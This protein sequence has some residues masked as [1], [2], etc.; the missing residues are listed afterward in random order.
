MN[1]HEAVSA[2]NTRSA[3]GGIGR[4]AG[5]RAGLGNTRGGG[6]PARTPALLKITSVASRSPAGRPNLRLPRSRCG[7]VSRPCHKRRFV[8]CV[9][10]K[11]EMLAVQSAWTRSTLACAAPQAI[12][13]VPASAAQI[14]RRLIGVFVSQWPGPVMPRFPLVHPPPAAHRSPPAN[15]PLPTP[16]SQPGGRA[17]A[18][19]VDT[20]E[21]RKSGHR[22]QEHARHLQ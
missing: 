16:H 14:I 3:Y 17:R 10:A 20:G 18:V 9:A 6:R 15:S 22:G 8:T 13:S 5:V 19:S 7:M 21:L 11:P 1:A 2:L 12:N 4:S